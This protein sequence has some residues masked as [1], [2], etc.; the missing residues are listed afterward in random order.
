MR[1]VLLSNLIGEFSIR[2]ASNIPGVYVLKNEA[3]H[4]LTLMNPKLKWSPNYGVH[5]LDDG[6]LGIYPDVKYTGTS[7]EQ[8][9]N[10]VWR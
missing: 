8:F 7:Y 5:I 3:G 6:L 2:P 10:G 1:R 4:T 9:R